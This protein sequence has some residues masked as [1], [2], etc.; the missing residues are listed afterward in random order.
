MWGE[1]KLNKCL[2]CNKEVTPNAKWCNSECK[3]KFLLNGYTEE[4]CAEWFK[5]EILENLTKQDMKDLIEFLEEYIKIFKNS[6]EHQKFHKKEPC[7]KCELVKKL[8]KKLKR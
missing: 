4:Q 1:M 3:K 7:P 5:E 6:K 2:E 8:L